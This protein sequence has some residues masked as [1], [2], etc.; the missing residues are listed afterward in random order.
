[1]KVVLPGGSGVHPGSA[2]DATTTVETHARLHKLFGRSD[3]LVTG[4]RIAAAARLDGKWVLVT[5][6]RPTPARSTVDYLRA[7]NKS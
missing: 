1:M 6:Q 2:N 3:L 5:N 7:E 4:D